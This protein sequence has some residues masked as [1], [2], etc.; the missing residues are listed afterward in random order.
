MIKLHLPIVCVENENKPS[1]IMMD[2]PT[3]NFV[4]DYLVQMVLTYITLNIVLKTYI[5]V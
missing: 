4:F 2:W 1:V 5:K 3:I